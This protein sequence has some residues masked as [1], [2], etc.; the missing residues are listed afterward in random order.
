MPDLPN[1]VN[2][3]RYT[4]T[5]NRLL[6][7]RKR[8]SVY[9]WRSLSN[10]RRVFG[11]T[12]TIFP[13]EVIVVLVLLCSRR[14]LPASPSFI[15]NVVVVVSSSSSILILDRPKSATTTCP[16]D[17]TKQLELFKSRWM[18]LHEWRYSLNRR[19]KARWK[20]F[21]V[22]PFQQLYLSHN[23]NVVATLRGWIN[24]EWYSSTFHR[25]YN[26]SNEMI[27]KSF[28]GKRERHTNKKTHLI[29]FIEK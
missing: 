15:C 10:C 25:Q 3:R 8:R 28:Q 26:L 27:E 12:T 14:K 21:P 20:P 17:L 22:I 24:H 2:Q 9:L 4:L 29:V 19:M 18:I 7:K 6:N 11:L 16:S 23:V 13:L 5:R 1:T